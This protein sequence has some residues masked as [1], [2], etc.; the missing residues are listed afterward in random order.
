[1]KQFLTLFAFTVFAT[2]A[3]GQGLVTGNS[4]VIGLD[5]WPYLW[6]Q[7]LESGP[8]HF[9]WIG[10]TYYNTA[11]YPLLP[12]IYN[13]Y[14]TIYFIRYD[15]KGNPLYADYIRGSYVP[16][17]AFSFEGGL[18]L[19]GWNYADVVAS[20]NILPLNNA[21]KN[22]F[23]A[24]Y[25]ER[26][27]LLKIVSVWNNSASESPNSV[28]GMDQRDG[29][30]YMAGAA[31]APWN[32]AGYGQIGT[33][34]RDYLYV[35][36]F[37]RELELTGVFTAGM[38]LEGEYGYYQNLAV[39][40][41]NRGNVVVTGEYQGDRAPIIGGDTLEDMMMEAT[42]L[43]ALKLN[44]VLRVEWVQDGSLGMFDY[45]GLS[46]VYKGLPMGNGDMVLAARTSTGYFRL[47]EVEIKFPGGDGYTSN[48][49][50][51]RISPEGKVAWTSQLENRAEVILGKKKGTL[52]IQGEKEVQSDQFAVNLVS[53]ALQWNDEIL[54]LTAPFMNDSFQVN[55]RI[56]PKPFYSGLFVAA[57][58]IHTG[59]ELWGYSL[60]SDYMGINGFDV[61]ISG[62]VAL[63]GYSSQVKSMEVLGLDSV[64]ANQ[65]IFHLGLQYDGRPL[66]FNDAY[67]LQSGSGVSGA[68]LEVLRDG[69]VFSSL[70]KTVADPVL[71]GGAAINSQQ[72]YTAVL[73][74]LDVDN[75]LGGKFLTMQ[76]APV[77]PGNVKAFKSTA[78]ATGAYPMVD[79][80]GVDESG[81]FLFEGLYPGDYILLATADYKQYPEGVPTYSGGALSWND[82]SIVI[83]EAGTNFKSNNINLVEVPVLV[84]GDGNGQMSGN[85]SYEDEVTA[86]GTKG[87]PVTKTSV[88]LKRKATEV[89]SAPQEEEI[90]AYVETDELGDYIFGFVPNGEYILIV[91]IPG[92]PMEDTYDVVIEEGRIIYYGLDFIVKKNGIVPSGAVGVEELPVNRLMVFPNP[93]DGLIQIYLPAAGD[94]S[95]RIYNTIGKLVGSRHYNAAAGRVQIDMTGLQNGM[96]ILKIDGDN[97]SETLK[98]IKK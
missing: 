74:A 19:M 62:N 50:V 65:A 58:D 26:C 60:S 12:E 41:D 84:A 89:K 72:N 31:N 22:E 17:D 38:E 55:G 39:F 45:D 51:F 44:S 91:D 53:D 15:K 8:D 25:N 76:G 11:T 70:Y 9:Y 29:T 37:S 82:A 52:G 42:G 90:V 93:G 83:I 2:S 20:G 3:G 33:D 57:L 34:Y 67:P 95:V 47:G 16:V 14:P 23:L 4:D 10:S 49:V 36:R 80:V 81:V 13:D 56:L 96:Y 64:P 92:L 94:Y 46:R 61:D 24:R 27:E 85:V 86:K 59:K 43:F 7:I 73:A 54:Y 78:I 32:L 79:S 66:W 1:M 88:I 75:A 69:E 30:L 97:L 68:D 5:G 40:P 21:Y 71:I 77:F 28:I 6:P 18:T 98:Y 87:K 35:L 63:M 48:Q